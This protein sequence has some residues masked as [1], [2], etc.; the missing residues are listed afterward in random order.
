M[1][2][3]RRISDNIG[4]DF[5]PPGDLEAIEVYRGVEL[6]AAFGANNCGAVLFWTR[7]PGPESRGGSFWKRLGF[8]TGFVALWLLLSH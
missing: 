1:M 2:P 4:V 7:L 6:P 5:F 8:A 3:I